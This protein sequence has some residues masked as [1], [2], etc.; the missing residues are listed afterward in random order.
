MRLTRGERR[1]LWCLIPVVV[2]LLPPVTTWAAG[3]RT[4]V[5]GM[6][7]LLFWNALAVAGAALLMSVA[8]WVKERTDGSEAATKVEDP[9]GAS[10]ASEPGDE[11][12]SGGTRGTGAAGGT[13]AR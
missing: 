6:P 8:F 3:V 11:P 4:R 9:E 12:P 13:A 7:F 10:V 1:A 5:M 2:A